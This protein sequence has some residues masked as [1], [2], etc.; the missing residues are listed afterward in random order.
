MNQRVKSGLK[1]ILLRILWLQ[2]LLIACVVGY[3][4]Y[5]FNF[6]VSGPRFETP[7]VIAHERAVKTFVEGKGLGIHRFREREFF[8]ER[9]VVIA[10]EIWD[11]NDLN[12][13]GASEEYG[14]RYFYGGRV[15]LKKRLGETEHRPLKWEEADGIERLRSGG[16]DYVILEDTE[17]DVELER[18]WLRVL[19]PVHAGESCL[20]CHEAEVG[21]LLGAFDYLFSRDRRA[22]ADGED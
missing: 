11:V 1:K 7:F 16:K 9:S 5:Y 21:D 18:D 14:E 19:A 15:P 3:V 17:A 4:V 12:L 8:H 13:I 6:V 22:E 2:L 20:K 10:D